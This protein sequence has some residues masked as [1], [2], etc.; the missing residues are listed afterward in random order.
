M[1]I[2]AKHV[3]LVVVL[4]LG[5]LVVLQVLRGAPAPSEDEFLE[6]IHRLQAQTLADRSQ[7]ALPPVGDDPSLVPILELETAEFDMGT[8][9]GAKPTEKILRVFNRGKAP[10]K[11]TGIKTSCSCTRGSI[12][13]NNAIIPPGGESAIG[14]L[15]LPNRVPNF[16][17][18]KTLTILSND[19]KN[20]SVD[21]AVVAHIVPE[22]EITPEKADFGEVQKGA[23]AEVVLKIR[24]LREERLDITGVQ[25]HGQKKDSAM[26]PAVRFSLR[27]VPEEKWTSPGKAEFEITAALAPFVSPGT[28]RKG[29]RINTN[30]KRMP[31]FMSTI[32]AQ[33]L[34][35]YSVEP[36]TGTLALRATSLEDAVQHAT[37]VFSAE[38]PIALKK[39]VTPSPLLA[40]HAEKNGTAGELKLNVELAAGASA[41]RF[42]EPLTVFVEVGGEVF[43]ERIE[44]RAFVRGALEP[45]AAAV[46]AQDPATE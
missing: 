36:N 19:L 43:E 41:G 29:L 15:L 39:A 42:A 12:D 14:V 5:G 21:I 4:V 40:V 20:P 8:V 27:L 13:E 7:G 38:A 24:Q 33:V 1:R 16:Y 3:V 32:E 25:I 46:P 44:A 30:I 11:I 6:E 26:A 37:L 28:L 45:E 31:R 9:P 17:S 18:K 10:L 23:P 34:A 22:F 2:K 35:P